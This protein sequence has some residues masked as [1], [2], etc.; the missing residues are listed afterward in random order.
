MSWHPALRVEILAEFNR[1]SRFE[2]ETEH[3]LAYYARRVVEVRAERRAAYVRF[4]RDEE[5]YAAF[6]ANAA[7]RKR[8]SRGKVWQATHPPIACL[9][10]QIVFQPPMPDRGFPSP[11][12]SKRCRRRV[13][14][15][16]WR[17]KNPGARVG[18]EASMPRRALPSR[19]RVTP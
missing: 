8:L 17:A 7:A 3:V 13:K 9:G 1:L 14:Y 4:R 10:C 5:A 19:K 16:K 18:A 15:E 12:C 2:L 6:L 11:Y